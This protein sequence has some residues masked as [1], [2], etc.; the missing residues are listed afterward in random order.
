VV[1]HVEVV[2][3]LVLDAGVVVATVQM[4]NGRQAHAVDSADVVCF[5]CGEA[6]HYA[7]Q[8]PKRGLQ[9]QQQHQDRGDAATTT[10]NSTTG[11]Q[12]AMVCMARVVH[13]L[14]IIH[15]DYSV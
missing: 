12:N 6:G 13:P 1:T 9:A 11:E 4:H 10:P 7:S 8:C 15:H 5:S 3:V 14:P 2:L